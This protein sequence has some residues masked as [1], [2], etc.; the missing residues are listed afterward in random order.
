[1]KQVEIRCA[2]KL[3][4]ILTKKKRIK[5]AVG[6]RGGSKSVLFADAVLKYLEDGERVMCC[7]EFQ[8]SID[9]SV[10]ALLKDRIEKLGVDGRFDVQASTI[11]SPRDGQVVYKGLSRNIKAV[12]S[13]HGF[14]H[15]WIEEG[16][17]LS[18]DS[19]DTMLPAMRGG[20][21]EVWI[22]M[23]RGSS[24]DPISKSLLKKH[25]ANLK[26]HGWSEDDDVLVIQ[27]NYWENPFFPEVLERQRIMDKGR[28]SRARYLHIWHGEYSDEVE[29]SIIL[30]EW[31]DACVDAHKRLGIKPLGARGLAFD[32]SDTGTDAKALVDIHGSV[33]LS[34]EERRNGDVND[35]CDWALYQAT[36]RAIDVFIWDADGMGASL[37]RPISDAFEGKSVSVYAFNGGMTA[38]RPDNVYEHM[39]VAE[40]QQKT[41]KESFFNRR[42][43]HYAYL[44]DRIFNT[45]TAIEKGEY[46]DPD[47]LI[48]FDSDGIDIESLRSEVCRVPQ[49]H[50][51]NM[52]F[53]V[54][55]KAEMRA[56]GIESPNQADGLMMLQA[57]RFVRPRSQQS[58]A[59][60][61]RRRTNWRA[62]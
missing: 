21:S 51:N 1:M 29:D 31:F 17:T 25:E 62:A 26:H 10:H 58:K 39:G 4:P 54:R 43:Q 41:N 32:P 28:M 12:K 7:R 56:M 5:I 55:T 48:C 46:M 36:T 34:V 35:A 13:M 42:A 30:P 44:R 3:L 49:K 45:Y 50:N 47:R 33:V 61:P 8:N 11:K 16:E 20:D 37:R 14:K 57:M 15:V 27:I 23:N 9:E 24:N 53:Q 52:R 59:P 40:G 6:G 18:Q 19:I 60:S 2:E 22:R 38:E